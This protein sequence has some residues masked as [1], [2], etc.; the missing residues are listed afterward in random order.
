MRTVD[1]VT[2]AVLMALGGVV[3]YDAARLGIGWGTDGPKSGFFPF[4]LAL[5][6]VLACAV[7]VLRAVRSRATRPFATREQLAPVAKVVTPMAVMIGLMQGVGL[8]VAAAL[9]IGF[10]MRWGGRHSWPAV[11]AVALG[12]PIVTFFVFETWFLVP[13]PKGPVEH[14]LGY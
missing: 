4:W 3:L 12:V 6:M 13:M 14:W 9:Y 8:Y 5:L 11:V 7:I 2:A 1:V 10:Y